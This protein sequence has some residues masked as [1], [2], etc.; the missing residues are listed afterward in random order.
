[1]M[2]FILKQ[3][4]ACPV[5]IFSNIGPVIQTA[6]YHSDGA[7]KLCLIWS[8]QK[9]ITQNFSSLVMAFALLFTA[10]TWECYLYNDVSFL[11]SAI[12]RLAGHVYLQYFTTAFGKPTPIYPWLQEMSISIERARDKIEI[13]ASW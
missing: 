11:T 10:V 12:S 9:N 2:Y 5:F 8:H 4:E 7:D 13:L 3:F 1:M 6:R